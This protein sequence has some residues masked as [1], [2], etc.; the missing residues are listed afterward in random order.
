[1]EV[2][3]ILF[4]F[5]LMGSVVI[6]FLPRREERWSWLIAFLGAAGTFSLG[7]RYLL[8]GGEFLPNSYFFCDSL[9]AFM[10]L[11]IG[12]FGMVVSLY[13]K[14]FPFP[15]PPRFFTF[16]LLT[17]FAASGVVSSHNLFFLLFFWGILG[18]LLFAMVSLTGY[19]SADSAKKTALIIIGSDAFLLFGIAGIWYLTGTVE[20]TALHIPITRW[21][22]GGIFLS[23]AIAG[24][25]KAGAMPFHSWIPDISETA[26]I[27][28]MAFLPASLDKLL[29]IYLLARI[30]N[31]IF[32]VHEGLWLLL[33]SIG[34]LTILGGVFMA[35]VQKDIR[36]LLAY[37][38]VSQ[39]GYMVIGIASA[40]P[41]GVLGGLFHMVNHALYKSALFLGAGVIQQKVAST[42][43][44]SLGGLAPKMPYTFFSMLIASLAISGIPPL[45]GFFSKLFIY[46][47]LLD[48]AGKG[49]ISWLLLLTAAML[50][51]ALTLASFLKLLYAA[52]L[53]RERS[54]RNLFDSLGRDRSSR[55]ISEAPVEIVIPQVL[56]AF[57][58]IIFGLFFKRVSTGFFGSYVFGF[59]ASIPP[60][61]SFFI[62]DLS[63]AMLLAAIGAGMILFIALFSKPIRLSPPFIGG[64][65]VTESMCSTGEEFYKTIQEMEPFSSLY[66]MA[67]QKVFDLYESL[68]S[69]SRILATGL[70][71]L[72]TGGV[73]TYIA[74]V[75]VG[76]IAI[77][78]LLSRQAG[79]L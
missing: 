11:G 8:Y 13:A 79:F 73:G 18:I 6:L 56:L 33:R 48:S 12:F 24:L 45:N 58:C 63:L 30:C 50:G 78:F 31:G 32:V 34:A 40:T 67:D 53:G 16:F 19:E 46:R 49:G 55:L 38:A 52:F 7:V 61:K 17:L 27:P 29:G 71:S 70:R 1:M 69:F 51:S 28:V 57:F 5:L 2:I 76:M 41:F 21:L 75:L 66:R 44:K 22:S 35:L 77:L 65:A 47:G 20:I 14:K 43:I 15:S 10:L 37:H 74:W 4:G 25:A 42:Y 62:L 64:E 23:I 39:V 54:S 9:S 3:Y 72:H 36:K 59:L 60:E 26:S 68:R